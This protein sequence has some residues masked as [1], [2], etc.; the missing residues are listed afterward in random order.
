MEIKP[1]ETGLNHPITQRSYFLENTA[2][3]MLIL[4]FD[5]ALKKK[6]KTLNKNSEV[7]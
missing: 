1:G 5:W 4:R 7:E 6:T 3:N 2:F